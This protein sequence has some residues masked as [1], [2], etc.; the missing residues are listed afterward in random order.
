MTEEERLAKRKPEVTAAKPVVRES[1]K[2]RGE[3]IRAEFL[4]IGPLP[5]PATLRAYDEI[6]PGAADRIIS[7][8]EKQAD[9]RRGLERT[10]I[11]SDCR[12][13]DRGPVLGF[14]LA[15]LV[16]AIGAA[17]VAS[18]KSTEGISALLG[19]LASIVIPFIYSKKK[20]QEQLRESRFE[21]SKPPSQEEIEDDSENR[22]EP[23][24]SISE[25][26]TG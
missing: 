16:I 4:H 14:I 9:H 21:D 17:L 13:Q 22:G 5:D 1:R 11:E 7:M 8:A 18:G 20:Q 3:L 26:P 15:C 19:A 23:T 6:C 25:D 12:A 10:V 2:P 24:A